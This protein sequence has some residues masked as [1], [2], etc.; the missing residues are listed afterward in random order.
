MGVW[1]AGA[2]ETWDDDGLA[3]RIYTHSYH[4]CNT[5]IRAHTWVRGGY[6]SCTDTLSFFLCFLA[7][8]YIYVHIH[9][10]AHK[11]TH[12]YTY[13][14]IYT[15]THILEHTYPRDHAHSGEGGGDTP[16]APFTYYLDI[17]YLGEG[18]IPRLHPLHIFS[19]LCTLRWGGD[20][21]AAPWHV[22]AYLHYGKGNWWVY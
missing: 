3:W 16:A 9:T 7:Y 15:Y 5:Y 4:T 8:T 6:P 13:I 11:H 18:E 19:E 17:A 12:I 20:T 1:S 21:P 22:L 14:H 2:D 10:Y